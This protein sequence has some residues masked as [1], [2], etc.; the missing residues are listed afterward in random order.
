MSIFVSREP[1]A[2]SDEEGNTI[3]IRPKMN[4][5]TRNRVLSAAAHFSMGS[6]SE[7]EIDVGGYNIALLRE[8]IVK[9]EGP[10]FDGQPF[11][12]DL[13]ED[14]DPAAPL[15]ERVLSEINQRNTA[16]ATPEKK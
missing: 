12:P 2:V 4:Y 6:G 11:A 16:E 8:N 9:W 5:G 10:I 14:L 3:Y 1:V 13:V 15:L 7:G